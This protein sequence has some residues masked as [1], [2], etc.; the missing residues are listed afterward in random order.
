MNN[1]SSFSLKGQK[2]PTLPLC[3]FL[4]NKVAVRK[5]GIDNICA[6][7][8]CA[9]NDINSIVTFLGSIL[10]SLMKSLFFG[11]LKYSS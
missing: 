2:P 4:N 10:L 1:R 6:K 7:Y 5:K 9:F 8:D 11:F 3:R